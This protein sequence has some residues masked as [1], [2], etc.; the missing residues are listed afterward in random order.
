MSSVFAWKKMALRLTVPLLLVGLYG[1][2]T[3][4]QYNELTAEDIDMVPAAS[5]Q[6]AEKWAEAEQGDKPKLAIAFGGGASRGM[7]H[8][9]V[10]KALYE[11]GIDADIVTG[12]SVGSIA[13]ALYSSNEY[14]DIERKMFAF[15]EHEI[16]DINLSGAGLIK[17]KALAKW[18]DKHAGYEDIG[19]LPVTTGIVATNLTQQ[20]AVMFTG[21][22]IGWAVQTSS[23]VPGV[24]VPVY[25]HGDILVDGGVLSLVPVYAARQLGADIVI[26]VDVFCSLPPP[27]EYSAIDTMANTFWV[28]SCIAAQDEIDSADIVL[29]PVSPDPSLVNF[30]GSAE[31]T[32]AMNVGYQA[33]MEA[34]P[35][36][37][38]KLTALK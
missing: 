20:K 17:G 21:G 22:D 6:S 4:N 18:I 35:A 11:A 5:V 14:P 31:R 15:S 7:M 1:C 37:K 12:T 32:A 26:A 8:L 23:S 25:H 27:L 3:V 2:S 24:F 13:A 36:L 38:A 19:D 30:G 16:V 10:M 29:A 33:M 28:Q 9:G 34:L